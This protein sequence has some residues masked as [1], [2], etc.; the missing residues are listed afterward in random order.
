MKN[1]LLPN[2]IIERIESLVRSNESYFSHMKSEPIRKILAIN[3][4]F[5]SINQAVSNIDFCQSDIISHLKETIRIYN[6]VLEYYNIKTLLDKHRDEILEEIGDISEDDIKKVEED[7]SNNQFNQQ[8][9]EIIQDSLSYLLSSKDK[10]K[11]RNDFTSSKIKLYAFVLFSLLSYI[12]DAN[13]P[14]LNNSAENQQIAG[15]VETQYLDKSN[16]STNINLNGNRNTI[17]IYNGECTDKK[18]K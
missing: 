15:V 12:K 6:Q 4:K 13:T 10:M 2:D 11:E 18:M 8:E 1:Q 3:K 17:N 9:S 5:S 7:L 14:M 16:N